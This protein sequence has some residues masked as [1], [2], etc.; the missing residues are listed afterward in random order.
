L[1]KKYETVC[2]EAKE[3]KKKINLLEI[4][5]YETRRENDKLGLKI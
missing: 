4:K 2:N 3:D 1:E 5:A